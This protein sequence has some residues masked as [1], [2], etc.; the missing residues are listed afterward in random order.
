M[1]ESKSHR[2]SELE[3]CSI[4]TQIQNSGDIISSI[5]LI[6]KFITDNNISVTFNAGK[7]RNIALRSSDKETSTYLWHINAL[8]ASSSDFKHLILGIE[9]MFDRFLGNKTLFVREKEIQKAATLSPKKLSNKNKN[10]NKSKKKKYR[11]STLLNSSHHQK[12]RKPT[13]A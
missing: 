7:L 8:I 9:M 13:S 5:L 6:Y 1:D 12:K 10:K 2:Q 3:Y 11:K 4:F